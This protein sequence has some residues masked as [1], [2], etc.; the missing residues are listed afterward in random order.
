MKKLVFCLINDETSIDDKHYSVYPSTV[1]TDD[2]VL[3]D[4]DRSCNT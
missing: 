2:C 3:E 1:G 4:D